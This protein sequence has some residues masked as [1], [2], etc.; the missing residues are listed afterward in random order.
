MLLPRYK[1]LAEKLTFREVEEIIENLKAM[2]YANMFDPT[3]AIKHEE[4]LNPLYAVKNYLINNYNSIYIEELENLIDKVKIFKT[5]FAV[6]DIRQNHS[7]HKQTIEE[8]LK[9]KI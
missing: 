5:H 6:L 2:L 9:K 3:K 4:I 8:I 1:D 7:V